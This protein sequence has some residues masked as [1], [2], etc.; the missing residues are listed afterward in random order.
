MKVLIH[1]GSFDGFLT[2][3]YEAYYSYPNVS[4]IFSIKTLEDNL[5][6]DKVFI[7]TDALKSSKVYTAL[8]NKA[9]SEVLENIY[10]GYLSDLY[11]CFSLLLEYIRLSFKIGSII[12]HHIYDKKV[13]NVLDLKNKVLREA[14]SFEGFVRFSLI[15]DEFLYSSIEPDHNI[16]ELL[17]PHFTERF[18]SEK[19]II[20][21]IK[22]ELALV[23][24]N[25]SC[26]YEIIYM[27]K[28]YY[29]ELKN[30]KEDFS[31]LWK[32]YYK[33]TTIKERENLVLQRNKMPKR[34]W[35]HLNETK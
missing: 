3:V 28:S 8:A 26:D 32:T 34:Y 18:S 29:N 6:Y 17:A 30:Y 2:C 13:K 35:K 16:L 9:G 27:S 31:E 4:L 14:H 33:S 15:N 1:D 22:R 19:F 21:D 24:N 10:Y 12:N 5:L 25:K 20:H 7:E 11:N 23:Y